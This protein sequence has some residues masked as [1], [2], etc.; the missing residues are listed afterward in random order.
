MLLLYFSHQC[1]LMI[2]DEC[3]TEDWSNSV[4]VCFLSNKAVLVSII[5]SICLNKAH[6]SAF[7]DCHLYELYGWCCYEPCS[8]LISE[9]NTRNAFANAFFQWLFLSRSCENDLEHS[10]RIWQKQEAAY[11]SYQS[12]KTAFVSRSHLRSLKT[13]PTEDA[14]LILEL[15]LWFQ[16]Q[17]VM[18]D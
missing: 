10:I 13:L 8:R 6:Y 14:H 9:V 11:L 4:L 16:T 1:I 12:S 17:D 15:S 3:D 7:C 2:S 18:Q 5:I